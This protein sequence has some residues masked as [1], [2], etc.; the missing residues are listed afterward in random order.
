MG[1]WK[2]VKWEGNLD[3]NQRYIICANHG[4]ELDI[5]MCL[6]IVPNCFVFIGKK[7]L[8]D[9][10]IFGFFYRRTNI[11]VD[12]KSIQSKREVLIKARKKLDEGI[13]LCIF[14]EGGI[15]DDTSIKLAPFKM[16]AFKLAIESGYPILPITFPDNKKH[17]PEFTGGG[18]PGRLRV[19]VHEAIEMNDLTQ[20]DEE[21]LRDRCFNLLDSELSSYGVN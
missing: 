5:M 6:A 16:G 1:Y 19:T 12:R 4:S 17:F 11:L 8:A 3:P 18:Y 9:V 21:A 20:E 15:P 13:G 7:E 2:K 14:P 10:P